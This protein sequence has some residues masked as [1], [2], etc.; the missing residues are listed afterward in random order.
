MEKFFLQV[1]GLGPA[2]LGPFLAA[3]QAGR[4]SDV[5]SKGVIWFDSKT[6]GQAGAIGGYDIISNSPVGDYLEVINPQGF[7]ASVLQSRVGKFLAT[8]TA[9]SSQIPLALVGELAGE[10]QK[11]LGEIVSGFPQSQIQTGVKVDSIRW[12]GNGFTTFSEGRELAVSEKI[13]LACGAQEQVMPV[14]VSLGR[15]VILASDVICNRTECAGNIHIFGASHSMASVLWKLNRNL[16]RVTVWHRSSVKFFYPSVVEAKADGYKFTG[17]DVCPITGRV[18][19]FG[20][21]RSPYRELVQEAVR[22]GWVQFRFFDSIE[23]IMP[24]LVCASVIVQATGFRANKVQIFGAEQGHSG[25]LLNG[26]GHL[27]VDADC[28]VHCQ[29]CRTPIPGA[30]ALGLGHQPPPAP[31]LGGEPSYQGPVDGFNLY[32]GTVGKT[33]LRSLVGN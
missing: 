14:L 27:M 26:S 30:F 5:L 17:N 31:E 8:Q 32:G 28:R 10:L 9:R 24:E 13:L 15:K 7:F 1:L 25:P 29:C 3:D 21:I 23:S 12:D 33:V 19:R 22:E 16:G 2:G 18:H 20:G 11:R 4:L 6:L